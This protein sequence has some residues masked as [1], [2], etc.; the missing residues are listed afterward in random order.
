[1]NIIGYLTNLF[2]N[3][4]VSKIQLLRY[5]ICKKEFKR[6]SI[7]ELLFISVTIENIYFYLMVFFLHSYILCYIVTNLDMILNL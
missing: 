1:M 5:I 2:N 3:T 7:N 4:H 6:N